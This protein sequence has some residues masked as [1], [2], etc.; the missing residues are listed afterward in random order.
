MNKVEIRRRELLD[1]GILR[2]VSLGT[3]QYD[4]NWAR[5]LIRLHFRSPSLSDPWN[6]SCTVS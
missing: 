6:T 3:L 5:E 1:H 2:E 4:R